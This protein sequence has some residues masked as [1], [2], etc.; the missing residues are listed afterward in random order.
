MKTILAL[1]TIVSLSTGCSLGQPTNLPIKPWTAAVKII[2]ED[3]QP[4][5]N[6]D[7]SLA[8]TKP[9]YSFSDNPKYHGIISGA[10]DSNG[11]FSATH[12]D[13]SGSLGFSVNKQGYYTTRN[14]YRLRDPEENANDRNISITL[15]LKKIGQPIG[16]Y[17]KRL[18]THVPDLDKPVGFDLMIGDW[19]APYGTGINAD[20]NFTGHFDKR[21]GGE[22]DFTLTVSFPKPG[23][24]IQEFTVPDAEKGS[25][26][27]SPHEAPTDGYK[28]EWV[29]FD[30][31]KPK[32]PTKTNKDATRN[33][34]F[35]VRT[36]L[37]HQGNVVST[38]YGKIYGDFMRFDYY[39]NPTSNSRNIE[40]DSKKN[41]LI[42]LK[43]DEAVA[44]P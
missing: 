33:Y 27:R 17:A 11:V 19:V 29:Q 2:G 15:P 25:E 41:L 18:N 40:F 21:D 10:T 6:A 36:V 7:V 13:R 30:N 42:G 20:I 16:M 22:S 34:F 5:S 9:P 35:R 14:A 37:D 32:T 28:S 26:L 1:I 31:R 12:D 3:G 24:G 4:V 44:A 38:H 23:D 39:L 8:Y 43:F